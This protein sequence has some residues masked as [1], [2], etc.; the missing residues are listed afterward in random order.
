MIPDLLAEVRRRVLPTEQPPTDVLADPESKAM[1][2]LS[3]PRQA[4][5]GS[6]GLQETLSVWRT[7]TQDRLRRFPQDRPTPGWWTAL[8]PVRQA[9]VASVALWTDED[10]EGTL[11]LPRGILRRHA[12]HLTAG[13]P[14][15]TLSLLALPR[16]IRRLPALPADGALRQDLLAVLGLQTASRTAQATIRPAADPSR[17]DA[18][19]EP[20]RRQP[21]PPPFPHPMETAETGSPV[22]K[23]PRAS[24]PPMDPAPRTS[25]EGEAS[26]TTMEDLRTDPEPKPS[27][28]LERLLG[29]IGRW[30]RRG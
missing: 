29:R 10:L 21:P 14:D 28:L 27:G 4:R 24:K 3:R 23:E 19:P 26:R 13:D 15:G 1:L 8:D 12:E 7:E 22:A 30:R 17:P 2:L 18:R 6:H 20:G 11:R 16:R 25:E 9:I 5:F